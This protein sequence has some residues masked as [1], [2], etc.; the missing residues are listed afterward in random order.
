MLRKLSR[1]RRDDL[2]RR[3]E[4]AQ[5]RR[6]TLEAQLEEVNGEAR[7]LA[8]EREIIRS[9]DQAV[10]NRRMALAYAVVRGDNPLI[11]DED[12]KV[13]VRLAAELPAALEAR[14]RN[15]RKRLSEI[16]QSLHEHEFDWSCDG[17]RRDPNLGF[18]DDEE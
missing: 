14:R 10:A 1:A 9:N 17:V 12:E 4:A 7:G 6:R 3:L 16:Y 8:S 5:G 18:S 15:D 2:D 13:V 11:P